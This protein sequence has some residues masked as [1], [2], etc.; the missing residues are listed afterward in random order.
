MKK[1]YLL[2]ALEDIVYLL[3]VIV[4]VEKF[5]CNKMHSVTSLSLLLLTTAVEE[6]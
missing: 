1:K 3:N 2:P 5:R 4:S 6:K